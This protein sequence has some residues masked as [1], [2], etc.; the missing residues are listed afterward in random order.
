[1][2]GLKQSCWL[3]FAREVARQRASRR[4]QQTHPSN[5][6]PALNAARA[7]AHLARKTH[8]RAGVVRVR[9]AVRGIRMQRMCM[10]HDACACLSA[11]DKCTATRRGGTR[12]CVS[13]SPCLCRMCPYWTRLARVVR[14]SP[15]GEQVVQRTRARLHS[16]QP[17]RRRRTGTASSVLSCDA[18][19]VFGGFDGRASA[20][21]AARQDAKARLV[22]APPR[23]GFATASA[24][25]KVCKHFA[26]HLP[27]EMYA[28][29]AP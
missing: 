1:M 13:V 8:R 24:G 4:S 15:A 5:Y 22:E 10:A 26:Q 18:E 23:R 3:P 12:Q 25:Q 19:V 21:T 17:T 11:C 20:P 7:T 29:S 2:I 28:A 14:R 27:E 9:G 6:A 16:R